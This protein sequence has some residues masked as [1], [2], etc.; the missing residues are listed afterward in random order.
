MARLA[1]VR[2]GKPSAINNDLLAVIGVTM[3]FRD[4]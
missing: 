3:Q 4:T 2:Y 1:D